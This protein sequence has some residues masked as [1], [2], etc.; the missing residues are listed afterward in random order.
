MYIINNEFGETRITRVDNAT[1]M[2]IE[3][4]EEL[5]QCFR[6]VSDY[7]IEQKFHKS[8]SSYHLDYPTI[9]YR[10]YYHF[11]INNKDVLC[12]VYDIDDKE[13]VDYIRAI[14]IL[15]YFERA[16]SNK[17][18][19]N[20][21]K[22]IKQLKNIRYTF[23]VLNTYF[24]YVI[25]EAMLSDLFKEYSIDLPN[26]T[27]KTF[28]NFGEK[29]TYEDTRY[30]TEID[31][32][33]SHFLGIRFNDKVFYMRNPNLLNS[34]YSSIINSPKFDEK[35][36][37]YLEDRTKELLEFIFGKDNVYHNVYD[38]DGNEQDFLVVLE[39]EIIAIEC[40]ATRFVEPFTN[41]EKAEN[42]LFDSD[43][44]NK[45]KEVLNLSE[46]NAKKFNS[47]IV[48]LESYH[49]LGT[50]LHL[51]IPR[52][53]EINLPLVIDINSFEIV[54]QKCRQ[55]KNIKKFL[56]YLSTRTE[57]FGMV[58]PSNSDEL[59]CFGYYSKYGFIVNQKIEN[60]HIHIGGGYASFVTDI[61]EVDD[62][63]FMN[64]YFGI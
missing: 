28:L 7:N 15:I 6:N 9:S 54:L 61:L 16:W 36:G 23:P 34:F 49:S 2:Y 38:I 18:R 32:K 37:D 4:L 29:T 53:E 57:Y 35:K 22:R 17:F 19:F 45:R 60:L 40:K 59:S 26:F 64:E 33:F 51:R 21:R 55:I 31:K 44:A 47:I 43:K 3:L 30:L 1:D 62:Y 11:F 46:H 63:Y 13:V 20:I 14:F 27:H 52:S 24:Y 8:F 12:S 48:T 56:D 58:Y 41:V 42:Q 39:N 50:D 25:P 10:Q 5:T